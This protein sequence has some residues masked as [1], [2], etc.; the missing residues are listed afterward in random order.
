MPKYR[1]KPVEIEAVQIKNKMTV[2]TLEGVMTGNPG[3]WLITGVNG[4]QYFCKD[5]IFQKTYEPV[6]LPSPIVWP[7]T[8][9]FPDIYPGIGD[10]YPWPT[11]P[12]WPN[13]P[14]YWSTSPY[15]SC[16]GSHFVTGTSAVKIQTG[17]EE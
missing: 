2:E 14:I 11:N 5:E 10:T 4:E 3:D 8:K 1:K 13:G 9:P 6:V 17:V 12:Q 15:M 16:G 7:T